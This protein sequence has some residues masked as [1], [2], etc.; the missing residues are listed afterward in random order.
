MRSCIYRY[1]RRVLDESSGST[2]GIPGMAQEIIDPIDAHLPM[3]VRLY[4]GSWTVKTV[5]HDGRRSLATHGG[6]GRIGSKAP[7]S[8]LTKS[9]AGR[10]YLLLELSCRNVIPVDVV[11]D[12]RRRQHYA[13]WGLNETT[14][15]RQRIDECWDCRGIQLLCLRNAT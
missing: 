4:R 8:C 7:N 2:P 11:G 14:D 6:P 9:S 10:Q 3:V 12:R 15:T 13:I 5:G 1:G